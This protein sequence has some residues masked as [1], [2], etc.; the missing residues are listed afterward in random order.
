MKTNFQTSDIFQTFHD[1]PSPLANFGHPKTIKLWKPIKLFIMP[2]NRL[3]AWKTTFQQKNIGT[4]TVWQRDALLVKKRLFQTWSKREGGSQ[5]P[6]QNIWDP[7]DEN[8]CLY[9]K[10]ENSVPSSPKLLGR[11]GI[12]P[13]LDQVQKRALFYK[14]GVPKQKFVDKPLKIQFFKV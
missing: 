6:D 4:Y 2:W 13:G 14:E 8:T 11:E 5:T 12:N 3:W 9:W 10:F 1:P 7:N